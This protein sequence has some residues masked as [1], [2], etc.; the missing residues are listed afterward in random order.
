[1]TRFKQQLPLFLTILL[2]TTC[3]AWSFSFFSNQPQ[4]I[5]LHPNSPLEADPA[6]LRIR[7]QAYQTTTADGESTVTVDHTGGNAESGSWGQWQREGECSRSCGGG[8][9]K[10]KRSCNGECTGASAR[11]FSCNT[12]PCPDDSEDFRAA[13]CSSH[14]DDPIDG[15]YYKWIPHTGANKCELTCKPTIGSFYYKWAD[16][17]VDGTKCDQ[18]YNDICVDGV[19]LPLGCDG[20]LGSTAKADKC[21][22][23]NGKGTTC[24][25]NDGVIKESTLSNGYNDLITLPMGA[26]SIKIEENRPTSNSLALKNESGHYFL[27]GNHQLQLGDGDVS[28]GGAVFKY[29]KPKPDGVLTERLT[30]AGP[31]KEPVTVQLLFQRGS[32]GSA[33]KY[34]YWTPLEEDLPYIYKPGEWS[35][36]SVSCGK[37]VKTRSAFC[38]DQSNNQRVEDELCEENNST[39]PEL[40][41]PCQTVDC[42]AEWFIGEWESCSESCGNHGWKY[43]VVYCH[44]VF[45]NGKR[46]T[47]DDSNCTSVERPAVKRIFACSEKCG[48]AKQ[49]RS[50]T[51]RSEKEG[52]E[53]KLL[54]ADQCPGDVKLENERYCNLGPCEGLT[55]KTSDWDL[56]ER[57]NDTVETRNVTCSDETGRLYP[58]EKCLS[59]TETEIPQDSRS[60]ATSPPCTYEWHTSE[61]SKCST[62]CGHGHKTRKVHCAINELGNI[63][64]LDEGLCSGDKPVDREE[65]VNE[66]KCTGTYFTGPWSNCSEECGGGVQTRLIACLNYDKKPVP[67]WCDEKDRPKE[68]QPCNEDPCPTCH[69]AEFGCCLNNITAADGP[70]GQGCEEYGRLQD[71]SGEEPL[72]D[73]M[74]SLLGEEDDQCEVTNEETGE[75]VNI[76]CSAANKTTGADDDIANLLLGDGQ[77]GNETEVGGENATVRCSKTEFG[78]CP[79]WYTP[80]EGPK[81]HGCPDF[82][83]GSCNDTQYG[84]CS[85]DEVTLARGPN[86]EGCGDP[87]C[88]ASLFG[89]CKDRKTIAFGPHY[90]G[91]ERSTFDCEQSEYGCCPDG[92]TAALGKNGTGCGSDCLLTKYG[93]CP[94][95]VTVAKGANNENCGCQVAQYGCCPD[96]KTD[97]KGPNFAGCPETCAQSRHGCCPD[98]KTTARGPNKEGCPCQ[99]TRWGCCPDGETTA[100]GPRKEGCDDCRHAKYGCCPDGESKAFGPNFAGCP[101]TTAAPYIVAGTVSP[102]RS[103]AC[104]LPEDKGEVCHRGYQLAWF[105]NTAESRCTQFWYGGCKGNQNRFSSQEE[106]EAVCYEPPEKGRCY[107]PKVEGPARCTNLAARYWYD[108][109]TKQ[110]AAFW[111][112]GCLGNANN[113][114]TFEECISFCR[115]IGPLEEPTPQLPAPYPPTEIRRYEPEPRYPPAQPQSESPQH[116]A[117]PYA[118]DYELKVSPHVDETQD[119]LKE[120]QRR[121]QEAE[122]RTQA[123]QQYR[124]L[125]EQRRIQ[126]EEIRRRDQELLN[127]RRAEEENKRQQVDQE[128]QQRL[129]E[130]RRQEEERK[131]Q[132]RQRLIQIQQMSTT[133]SL[134]TSNFVSTAAPRTWDEICRLAVDPGTCDRAVDMWYFDSGTG[135]CSKFIYTNCGGNYNRFE[136]RESCERSCGHLRHP[137]V[138]NYPTLVTSTVVSVGRTRRPAAP[139]SSTACNMPKDVG[140]CTGHF[141]SYYYDRDLGVCELFQYSGCGGNSNRFNSRLQC[142]ET[143]L[144]PAPQVAA[145]A[146]S[147]PQTLG[148]QLV[149]NNQD[150]RR[151]DLPKDQGPCSEFVHKWY[152]NN[153]DGTCNKFYYGGCQ[154]NTNRYDSESECRAAC[155][156]HA[157]PCT[158]PPVKGPC[159]G[160]RRRYYYNAQQQQCTEFTYGGCIPN[161]NNFATIEECEQRCKPKGNHERRRVYTIYDETEANLVENT[162]DQDDEL[163]RPLEMI[164]L[165]SNSPTTANSVY[166]VDSTNTK[167]GNSAVVE[168]ATGHEGDENQIE[169]VPEEVTS[170]PQISELPE[171]CALPEDRGTCY[172]SYVRYRYNMEKR[173]CVS[174]NYTGCQ[175]NP[176]PNNFDSI[177]ACE[178]A[179]GRYRL[180]DVCSTP[181]VTG[182]C[183]LRIH[184]WYYDIE[185]KSCKIFLYSGCANS[186]NRFSSASECLALCQTEIQSNQNEDACLQPRDSGPCTD[187][188]TQ[189][190]YDPSIGDCRKFTFGG[191]RGSKNRFN[192]H[193]DCLR[194]CR[195]PVAQVKA[196]MDPK[197]V[198][199]MPF[200]A[201]SCSGVQKRWFFDFNAR[202]CRSFTYSGCE[203]NMNNHESELECFNF[204]KQFVN[205]AY[206]ESKP[207]PRIIASQQGAFTAG[208]TVELRC[209]FEASDVSVV[210]YRND[211]KLSIIDN[212]DRRYTSLGNLLRIVNARPQDG[213]RFTCASGQSSVLSEPFSVTIKALSFEI[214]TD[215][216]SETTCQMVK[217]SNLCSHSRYATFCCR[218]C[219][220]T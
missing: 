127:Q 172:G 158:L 194:Q 125:E 178:R 203:G 9:Y 24:K 53:G 70:D 130:Q 4:T 183:N 220:A 14:D 50:V 79:D 162:Q 169:I 132:E 148:A 163:G 84:C 61:W 173:K 184:K 92:E 131:E 36:C 204:C 82:V 46:M 105:Y 182:I 155:G 136:S 93:C 152:Y 1:M 207:R 26:T 43:R 106:C 180:Q 15:K 216:G 52:E 142:E 74:K 67:E 47:V 151:C 187:S 80:A 198:C 212:A 97:A 63:T 78:C 191:C 75:V 102:Q 114:N 208:A 117:V 112:R 20:K 28:A 192:T 65:C 196:Q 13:Q 145:V 179:C 143:C 49:Y 167:G 41:K 18:L 170:H 73:E 175:S 123:E 101:S 91:C 57:C 5:S 126:E 11:Y 86:Q 205:R 195:A 177:D 25:G 214:C 168:F 202:R 153:Q 128:Y 55:F 122:R 199:S 31:L 138:Q 157:D 137:I 118:D 134:V 60:C 100:L 71:G 66:E 181:A 159:E 156:N 6:H 33:V 59:E 190:Y 210:W 17:V 135:V 16:K 64:I 76:T 111:Y 83:L 161:S 166:S 42:E 104:N 120:E 40:E 189:W 160:N 88:A 96:G 87:S 115:G 37:G 165:N 129:E 69:E 150:S 54:S 133:T 141:S 197:E 185:S 62:E 139:K 23:C 8:V 113:F 39:K 58:L 3:N 154:G 56:C 68:E 119:Q 7:R 116:P 34:E 147:F 200:E 48:D 149:V 110:C 77:G 19:C 99:Y 174:F 219:T 186:G 206:I 213:G 171:L 30:A 22:V 2:V 85:N 109:E 21:G 90:L 193:N 121:A 10:E 72:E 98:G 94:D 95:G 140:R 217:R 209:I 176:N 218:T 27:N 32:H 35:A 89:C 38:T 211:T 81:Y 29:Q 108:Y 124:V 188:I 103:I 12:D 51:C 107:L 215:R 45:A 144:H 44:K 146:P 164:A 201:G